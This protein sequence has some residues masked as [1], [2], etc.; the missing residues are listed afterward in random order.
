M[1]DPINKKKQKHRVNLSKI[2]IILT[3][4]AGLVLLLLLVVLGTMKNAK[5]TRSRTDGGYYKV[6]D[7]TC[8]EVKDDKAPIGIRKEYTFNLHSAVE[9]DTHLAFYTVHQYVNVFLDGE[10][11]YSIQP[12][13]D[14][15]ICKTV[16]SNWVMLP[17]YRED[18]GKKIRIEITPVYESFR[19]RE[20]DFLIGSQLAIYRDRLVKDLPQLI[21]GIMVAFVGI[22]FI[23]VAGYSLI[24][25]R[26]GKSLASLGLFSVM[27]GLWRLTDTRFTPF[28]LPD[29]PV[30][31]FYVSVTMLML[32]M[33]PLMKWSKEYFDFKVHRVLDAYCI[34]A[35]LSCLGQLFLQ[36]AGIVDLRDMLLYTHIIIGVG[37]VCLIGSI[38][39]ERI[40]YPNK[41]KQ[42]V[43]SIFPY[44]CIAG[45][46]AD[47][48]AFYLKGNSSG[49]L[50]SM[51][52]FLLYIVFVGIAAM[53][54]Y[55]EQELVL[56]EQDRQLAEKDRE[57]AKQERKLTEQRITSMM[58]Q[59]RSHFIFN[60]LTTISSYCKV[61]AKKADR[62]L[63]RFSRYLR[64][65]INIIETDGLV[66]FTEELEQVEDYV[67]LE[68]MRFE[69]QIT[70]VKD[71]QTTSF[72][73]PPLTIQPIVE[74]AIKHGLVE[75]GRSGT[76][77]LNVMREED[78]ILIRVTDDGVGFHPEQQ[79]R[80]ESVGIKNVRYRLE[81]MVKGSIAIES[82]PGEGT[83]VTIKIPLQ[84]GEHRDESHLCG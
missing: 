69:D 44:L 15:R 24:K 78:Y 22:V 23:C 10:N 8:K 80:G 64:K 16:G 4:L 52:A 59:I 46:A 6:E 60:V 76:V 7:Y 20:V 36:F 81:N 48:A 83:T 37:V 55:S 3:I 1:S 21:L 28:I 5:V 9:K 57:L 63:I 25:N 45:V 67:A 27:M 62:A 56:A 71:I 14:N 33:I 29:K 35:A 53:F 65:N 82:S 47:I 34:L 40:K 79:D 77:C 11:V 38:F 26:R 73:I 41:P 12:S 49:L 54:H 31:L 30:F 68:Q 75:H 13:D 61:D 72:Q 19:D 2:S 50:F 74:N 43:S 66:D 32:G 58:S 51:S 17:L 70:F 84:E 42:I 39:Y 18:A